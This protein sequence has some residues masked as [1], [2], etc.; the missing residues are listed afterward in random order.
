MRI[1]STSNIVIWV[2]LWSLIALQCSSTKETTRTETVP[3]HPLPRKPPVP[4]FTVTIATFDLSLLARKLEQKDINQLTKI[5]QKNRIDILTVYGISRYPELKTR[6]DFVDEASASTGMRPAFGENITLSGRQTGNAV[7][8][9]Y[10]I[11]TQWNTRYDGIQSNNFESAFQTVIDCGV[12]DIVV[13]STRIPDRVSAEDQTTCVKLLGSFKNYYPDNPIVVTGNLPRSE[14][15]RS[16]T[17][18]NGIKDAKHPEAS[19]IWYTNDGSL[20]LLNFSVD[21]TS[22]SRIAITEFGIFRKPPQ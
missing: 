5:I 12:R 8:T 3:A 19:R 11:R 10:P 16:M 2:C 7:F 14:T 15:L 13:V 22:F 20:T 1:V 9:V 21:T 18:Y 6:L 17:Q 4:D